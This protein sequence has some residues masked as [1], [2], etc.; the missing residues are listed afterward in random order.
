MAMTKKDYEAVAR[1]IR[2]VREEF[3]EGTAPPA[4]SYVAS[5]LAS[6]F[7]ANNERFDRQRFIQAA[8]AWEEAAK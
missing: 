1:V 5:G 7:A 8:R 2:E 3:P 6:V 4:L